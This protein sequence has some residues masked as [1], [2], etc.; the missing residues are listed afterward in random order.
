MINLF[1][2]TLIINSGI[3]GGVTPLHTKDVILAETL[4]Y[5]DVDVTVFGYELGQVPNMPYEYKTDPTILKKIK[6]VLTNNNIDYKIG[7]VVT[8]DSFITS[9]KK[10]NSKKKN[11]MICEMEGASIAQTCH[12]LNTK[13]ISVRFVS[14]IIDSDEQV[15]NYI[16][17]SGYKFIQHTNTCAGDGS[18]SLGQAIIA[19]KQV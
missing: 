6:D 18:V 2:P 10:V 15:K 5:G 1:K 4:S 17:N 14:D 3:A 16:E 19:K 7:N 11:N 9:L 13:F 8:T 12:I